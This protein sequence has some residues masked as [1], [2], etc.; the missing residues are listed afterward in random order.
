MSTIIKRIDSRLHSIFEDINT[1]WKNPDSPN[2]DRQWAEDGLYHTIGPLTD[3]PRW[4]G[5]WTSR[6][7]PVPGFVP[8]GPAPQ[9]TP[10]EVIIAFAGDPNML[11]KSSDNPKSPSYGNQGGA[12]LYRLAKRVSRVYARDRDKSFIADM[13]SN[14]FI[15]LVRLMQPGF[16]EGRSPFIS[17]VMRTIQGAMEHGVGG[18]EEGIR[19]A[20]GESTSGVIGLRSVLDSN[21]PNKIRQI[22]NQVK[23]KYQTQKS[24]DRHPDNPFGPYSS[25]FYDVLNRYADALESKDE[26]KID[27]A[28]NHI[29]QLMDTI[30]DESI[31]IR[32]AS[33]GMGQAVST[34]DRT[35]HVGVASIDAERSSVGGE[36][37][38][39]SMAGNI[40]TDDHKDSWIDPESVKYVLQ[41]ALEHDIGATIGNMPKYKQKAI[42]WG[43]KQEEDGTI[44]LGGKLTANE[45]R[46]VIRALG[47]LGSNYPGSGV[48]RE[49]INIPRD[50][51]KWW[52]PGEDPEIEPIFNGNL[53]EARR[54]LANPNPV[55]QPVDQPI[56]ASNP[57]QRRVL[58]NPSP[59][60]QP[61]NV[62]S[63]SKPQETIRRGRQSGTW[64]S[65]WKREG[66]QQMGPTEMAQEMTNEIREFQKLGIKTARTIKTKIDNRTGRSIEEAVSKVAV[67]NTFQ[68]A[69][70]KLKLIAFIHR[71]QLGMD[72]STL[73]NKLPILEGLDSVDLRMIVEACDFIIRR[74]QYTMME[75]APAKRTIGKPKFITRSWLANYKPSND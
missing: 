66:F 65:K 39:K 31:P 3:N 46:Y 62:S 75:V 33:T 20:G 5:Q 23:G 49:A 45:L 71:S 36:G 59:V 54:V 73:C 57:G 48:Q 44:K 6:S 52:K 63:P 29:Q 47:P 43:A 1:E 74:I 37:D 19:A 12:P 70:L 64:T 55:D 21:D 8:G 51:N 41:I 15:P 16:D 61:T 24:H 18:T 69:L 40:P 68:A 53:D 9:W 60:N 2:Y 14:G 25:R 72:E 58:A 26:N 32:G 11:F 67:S 28:K 30:D 13:Y 17:Y 42:E 22:A 4:T 38:A 27:A 50:A 56:K 34:S 35:S 10:N 7:E